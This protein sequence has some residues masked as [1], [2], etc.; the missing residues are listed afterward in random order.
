MKRLVATV[1][2]LL[3]VLS[4][5]GYAQLLSVEGRRGE[6][7]FPFRYPAVLDFKGG[8]ARAQGMGYAFLGLSDDLSAVSWNPAGLYGQDR[9]Q[10]LLSYGTYAPNGKY[11]IDIGSPL[12][13]QFKAD[14]IL[15]NVSM[16][17]FAAPIRIKGHPFVG[18]VSYT[19]TGD[20]FFNSGFDWYDPTYTYTDRQGNAV[21]ALWRRVQTE[22][23][24]ALP[25][26]VNIGFGTRLS[27]TVSFGATA[28]IFTGESVNEQH[29]INTFENAPPDLNYQE[30][31]TQEN[32][33]V[34]DTSNFSGVNFTLGLK[35]QKEKLIAGAV[36][37]T[38]YSLQKK[39]D[40]T[41]ASVRTQNGL[42]IQE[43]TETKHYDGIVSKLELPV[44]VGAGASYQVRTNLLVA[45]DLEYRPYGQ[46]NIKVREQL[47]IIPGEKDQEIFSERDPQWRNVLTFRLGGEYQWQTGWEWMSVMPFRA[48][49]SLIPLASPD[50]QT[51]TRLRNI[52]DPS[53][54]GDSLLEVR[55]AREYS[56]A[57]ATSFS[58]GFGMRWPQ[59]R[60]D[61]AY[62][63]MTYSNEHTERVNDLRSN[64]TYDLPVAEYTAKDSQFRV[65]FT[66]YFE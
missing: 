32:W 24:H 59:V 66:G 12:R 19:R 6:I 38:P 11:T 35:Y 53:S 16:F 36:V 3:M 30:V 10:L 61:F 29:L 64:E 52:P 4:I 18:A 25:Y 21:D 34:R 62:T 26:M 23:Y 65:T 55:Q 5:G 7:T 54:P 51:N 58:V 27:Q 28:N 2:I 43:G 46:S 22:S 39:T 47:L 37:K 60:L 31:V 33:D 9:P 40:R 50:I 63:Y 20:E 56:T 48:G 41:L 42:Q 49:F 57:Y 14:D 17:A 15:G 1:L 45:G 13:R 8:G 44:V